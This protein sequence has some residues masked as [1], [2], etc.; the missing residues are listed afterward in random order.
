MSDLGWFNLCLVEVERL[1]PLLDLVNSP[2]GQEGRD[3]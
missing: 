3:E 2:P 1:A